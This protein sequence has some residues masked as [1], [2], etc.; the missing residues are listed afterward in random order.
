MQH[1][2]YT[3]EEIC[4]AKFVKMAN[5]SEKD[6][7]TGVEGR[8]LRA[9]G[10]STVSEAADILEMNYHTLRNYLQLRRDAPTDL[11]IRIARMTNVSL[12]WLL[13]GRGERDMTFDPESRIFEASLEEK[14][15]HVV[16]DELGQRPP[17][18]PSAF[19]LGGAIERY[20]TL[21]ATLTA[22]FEF[23][24]KELPAD[25]AVNFHGWEKL[26]AEDRLL[27]ASEIKQLIERL[28]SGSHEK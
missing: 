25:F 20:K 24:G 8:V 21:E 28:D 14:I 23:E 6:F 15:R 7:L 9:F 10:C 4:Q 13:T 17:R 22:W 26:S 2:L 27:T 12:D 19:D 16:R 1:L 5:K 18:E 11:W 3:G